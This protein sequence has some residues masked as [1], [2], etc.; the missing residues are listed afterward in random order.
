LEGPS[1]SRQQL[2][3]RDGLCVV[4]SLARAGFYFA[5]YTGK[6]PGSALFAANLTSERESD[7]RPHELPTRQGRA[8]AARSAADLT[9]A[10]TDWSW[11]LAAL[12]LLLI[13]VDV[14]WVTRKPRLP[15]LG[16]PRRPDRVA[17]ASR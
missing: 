2:P 8:L 10:V 11:L 15:A 7:L 12:S 6:S 16:L 5:N 17:E 3:A 1:G 4:P 9:S 13:A 14:W